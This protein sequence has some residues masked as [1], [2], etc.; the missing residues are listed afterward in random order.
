[1][2]GLIDN[3]RDIFTSMGQQELVLSST[4]SDISTKMAEA[5]ANT[6][7]GGKAAS[8]STAADLQQASIVLPEKVLEAKER[9]RCGW[10]ELLR[11]DGGFNTEDLDELLETKDWEELFVLGEHNVPQHLMTPQ[12]PSASPPTAV[13]SPSV[14]SVG[15][16]SNLLPPST[17]TMSTVSLL[18]QSQHRSGSA[19]RTTTFRA[20]S[21]SRSAPNPSSSSSGVSVT[22]RPSVASRHA[23]PSSA[24]ST[25]A[26]LK[27][28]VAEL[29]A[30]AD[31]K[32]DSIRKEVQ[33]AERAKLM[34]VAAS[35]RDDVLKESREASRRQLEAERKKWKE[36]VAK[37]E[38]RLNSVDTS[39]SASDSE[40]FDRLTKEAYEKGKAAARDE[41]KKRA[42]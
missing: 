22:V 36:E 27:Q 41:H 42:P 11:R 3:I 15:T 26:A 7:I 5:A 13:R 31:A 20:V 25:V 16:L 1:M 35:I 29:E 37:L 8:G 9:V 30:A 38:A 6:D 32:A 19:R 23:D 12:K 10:R 40:V 28:R 21:G 24:T 4:M 39:A 34:D 17:A 2:N 14:S 33:A 18:P